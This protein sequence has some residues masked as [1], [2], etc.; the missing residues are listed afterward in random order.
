MGWLFLLAQSE[1]AGR[2]IAPSWGALS[3]LV[4]PLLTLGFLV[5]DRVFG[6]GRSVQKMESKL[7]ELCAD[8]KELQETNG[9]M[10][11]HI[12]SLSTNVLALTHEWRGVDGQNGWKSIVRI[13]RQ[14]VT[15]INDRNSRIDAVRE[16]ER[17]QREKAGRP[18]ER[19][20]DKLENT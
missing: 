5:F 12:A 10:D 7:E 18:P 14:E 9:I 1:I 15:M 6:R 20:R 3:G 19:L 16:Y 8:V 11:A 4:L 13:L 17:E 2:P